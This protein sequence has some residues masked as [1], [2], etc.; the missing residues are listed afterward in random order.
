M[1][2]ALEELTGPAS[3]PRRGL[4]GR[5]PDAGQGLRPLR[6]RAHPGPQRGL[7]RDRSPAQALRG[8]RRH[9][10]PQPWRGG[11]PARRQL[12]PR[13]HRQERRPRQH[14]AVRHGGGPRAPLEPAQDGGAHRPRPRP[15][16]H[17]QGRLAV[18]H[19][20]DR[21][22]PADARAPVAAVAHVGDSRAYRLRDGRLEQLTQDHTWVN[23][24]VVAGFLSREQAR[25]H[26]LKNVVDA[27]PRRRERRP[28][29]RARDRDPAGRPLPP[30][31][32]R[33][34]RHALRRRPPRPPRLRPQPPRDLPH[35]DQRSNA[36]GGIDNV[37]VVLLAIEDDVAGNGSEADC[38]A[39]RGSPSTDFRRDARR[40]ARRR[41]G[42][43]LGR[44][45]A[46]PR[47]RPGR[48]LP[49]RPARREAV[50]RR[51][52]RAR[53]PPHRRLRPFAA[54]RRRQPRG[55]AGGRA[56][57][58][59]RPRSRRHPHLP[60]A[61]LRRRPRRGRAGRRRRAAPGQG[62]AAGEDGEQV[63]VVAGGEARVYDWIVGADGARGLS[64]RS[65][66][67]TPP[68]RQRR[69]RR[70]ALRARLAPPR[71]RL[72]RARR[73]LLLDL[74]ASRRRLGRHRLHAGAAQRGRRP[75]RARRLPRTPPAGRLARPPRP[76]LSLSDPRPR[77][78]DAGGGA[79]GT[80]APHPARRRRRGGRRSADPRG[81][82]LRPA[83][84]PLGRREPARRA[85]A[86]IPG[87]AGERA[88]GG[89]GEGRPRPRPL[90]RKLDRPLGGP[91]VEPPS[92]HPERDGDLLAC[93]QPYTGLRR[94]LLRAAATSPSRTPSAP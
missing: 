72:P 7:L 26:P 83:H 5:P 92:G 16:R 50:R 59:A 12:D 53:A 64:R 21:G 20:H 2:Q 82:P 8:R 40:R 39:T 4:F 63:R 1:R 29:R 77:R 60:A 70:L 67:L 42:R 37:T 45:R 31:L 14:L 65:L 62:R 74:P 91:A 68:R 81:D 35:P 89:D 55:P 85:P 84:R 27:R 88:G 58:P 80:G 73:R 49:P 87:K 52:A 6:R 66:G 15:A 56:R 54:P 10:R 47:R 9:G 46:R 71:P 93:R 41:T 23:E 22:R 78:L 18:R 13:V 28:G 43:R 44:P 94:R 25:S 24:Q 69:P 51:G 17:H 19:G 38:E 34:H 3:S 76:P 61:G 86:G 11:L 90:L 30:L 33:P 36:R 57:A 79:P 75:R 32:R 48:S